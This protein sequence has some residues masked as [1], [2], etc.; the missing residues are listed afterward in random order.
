MSQ[1]GIPHKPMGADSRG[2]FPIHSHPEIDAG[3]SDLAGRLLAVERKI[4][5]LSEKPEE[6]GFRRI[7][8]RVKKWWGRGG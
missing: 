7:V 2:E 6:K 1:L 5:V 8:S 3:L 4:E